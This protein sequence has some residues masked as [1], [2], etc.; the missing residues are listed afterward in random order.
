VN[1]F[2]V[3][4]PE[5]LDLP[6]AEV[7]LRFQVFLRRGTKGQV[8]LA[9]ELHFANDVREDAFAYSVRRFRL[10][11]DESARSERVE[12]NDKGLRK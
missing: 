4:F 9:F 8:V 3:R 10:C 7:V 2:S 5:H 12:F 11:T 6:P 1:D